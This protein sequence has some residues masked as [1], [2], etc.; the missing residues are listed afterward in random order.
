MTRPSGVDFHVAQSHRPVVTPGIYLH[1]FKGQ[2]RLY[3]AESNPHHHRHPCPSV[4]LPR[5]VTPLSHR[6]FEGNTKLS[7]HTWTLQRGF[8]SAVCDKSCV[9]REGGGRR[10]FEKPAKATRVD[11]AVSPDLNRNSH[12]KQSQPQR[13]GSPRQPVGEMVG[14]GSAES[15]QVELNRRPGSTVC[16]QAPEQH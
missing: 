14:R 9:G 16:V 4:D 8:C 15:C 7:H 11:I 10:G 5:E 6:R 3:S 12:N 2:P 13:A 1:V